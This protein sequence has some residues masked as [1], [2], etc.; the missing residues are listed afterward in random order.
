MYFEL[1]VISCSISIPWGF[2]NFRNLVPNF[3]QLAESRVREKWNGRNHVLVY[4]NPFR[5]I[6]TLTLAINAFSQ[7][8]PANAKKLS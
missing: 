3:V 6:H 1:D 5:R 8:R 2:L 7:S 4:A